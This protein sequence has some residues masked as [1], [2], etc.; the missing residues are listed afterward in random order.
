MI[1]SYRVNTRY[2]YILCLCIHILNEVHGIIC[3]HKVQFNRSKLSTN[4]LDSCYHKCS[5]CYY[6][7]TTDKMEQ[8]NRKHCV[9]FQLV[10]GI[11]FS[12]NGNF[13]FIDCLWFCAIKMFK[14]SLTQPTCQMIF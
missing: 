2:K 3:K 10:F 12:F 5:N 14:V 9:S 4:L 6:P 13:Q 7:D 11:K 1:I 8:S